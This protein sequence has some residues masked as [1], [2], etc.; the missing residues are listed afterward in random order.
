[1]A[2]AEIPDTEL[3]KWFKR[4]NRFMLLL[5]RLGL[6]SYGNGNRFTGY[7]MVM[8]NTGRK[9]GLTRH[10]PLNYTIVAGDVYCTAGFGA[11]SDWYRN[12]LKNP[13]VE[14]WLPTGRW[15]G[16]AE[17]ASDLED[18]AE[19]LRRVIVASGFAGPLFGVNPR[20]MKDDDFEALFE[21][22]RLVRI[23]R[24]EALTGPGGP[25]DLA[26][27]WPLATIVLLGFLL[28]PRRRCLTRSE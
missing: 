5:W 20:K 15:A 26:W 27:I 16:V 8:K 6:A 23:R 24:T 19:L 25:G 14:V 3:Q 1:M 4:F 22:Y 28:R 9:T 11:D 12:I 17:E 21:T 2:L 18:R 13:E 7:I 10:T